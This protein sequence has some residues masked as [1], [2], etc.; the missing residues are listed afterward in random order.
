MTV[1]TIPGI[2]GID[3]SERTYIEGVGQ[4][5]V[6][7]ATQDYVAMVNEDLARVTNLFIEKT[8][9][10][11]KF[12][13]YLPA[14]GELQRVSKRGEPAER[15]VTGSWDVALPL[16]GFGDAI[17]TSRRDIAYMTLADYQRHVDGVLLRAK[18]TLR[19]EILRAL[20]D[21]V[22]YTF[23]DE[24]R[25]DLAVK[26][27]ANTDGVLY[28]PVAG[29]TTA[30]EATHYVESNYATASITNTNNPIKTISRALRSRWGSNGDKRRRVILIASGAQDYVEALGDFEL[31]NDANIQK[32]VNSDTVLNLPV[33][34]PGEIIGYCNEAYVSVW[35]WVPANYMIGIDLMAE[36]P[37]QMRLDPGYTNLPRGLALVSESDQFPI[38]KSNWEWWFGLGVVNRLNGYV[39]E[40][41]T[42]GTYTVPTGYS[43]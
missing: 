3:D 7:Q 25:G 12:R 15:K 35:D 28:P 40:L 17:S 38:T 19:K 22:N 20:L 4:R 39:M 1:Q 5:Q 34:I 41:G 10:D 42:G 26:A 29:G 30:A 11:H 14:D 33:S 2:L 32:G 31:V 6:F 18:N 13:Y 23:P 16:E 37:L 9:E 27:L 24:L 43:H 36:K 8:T 21:N